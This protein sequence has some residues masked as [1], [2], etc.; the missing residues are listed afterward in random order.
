M[1]GFLLVMGLLAVLGGGFEVMRRI[2]RFLTRNEK[3]LVRQARR[4]GNNNE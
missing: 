1:K 4:R 2:D 3:E